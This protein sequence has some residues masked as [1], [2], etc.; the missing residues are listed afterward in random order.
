MESVMKDIDNVIV[1]I[2][3]LLA[4]TNTYKEHLLQLDAIFT[5]L[6]IHRLKVNLEKCTLD[7]KKWPTLD[8]T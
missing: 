8:S 4:H 3:D 2:D 1:Y 7:A 5:K 6:A